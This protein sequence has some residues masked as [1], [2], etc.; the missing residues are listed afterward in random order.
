MLVSC[1]GLGQRF[2]DVERETGMHACG[3]LPHSTVRFCATNRQDRLITSQRHVMYVAE[4]GIEAQRHIAT[5]KMLSTLV[6]IGC[7]V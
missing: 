3:S 6:I 1:E 7:S 2:A 4:Y 5:W